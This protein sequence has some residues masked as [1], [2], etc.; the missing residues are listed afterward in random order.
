MSQQS[1]GLV[2][3]NR[4]IVLRE[5]QASD[6]PRCAAR[7]YNPGMNDSVPLSL[8]PEQSAVIGRATEEIYVVDPATQ[9]R[10]RLVEEPNEGRLS[11]DELRSMLQVGIDEL[12][13]G[14]GIL[15]DPKEIKDE[16]SRRSEERDLA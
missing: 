13:R 15:W 5:E 10:Y 2:G 16:L 4:A 7:G 9:R 6:S 11:L 8:T 3:F 14:E 1:T 12:D